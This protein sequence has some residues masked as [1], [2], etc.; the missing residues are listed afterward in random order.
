MTKM[1]RLYNYVTRYI[2]EFSLLEE[3]VQRLSITIVPVGGKNIIWHKDAFKD[4]KVRLN[5]SHAKINFKTLQ[6][7]IYVFTPNCLLEKNK[8][9]QIFAFQIHKIGQTDVKAF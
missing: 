5:G 4:K 7:V 1:N 6:G 8:K 9:Y 3:V 2:W